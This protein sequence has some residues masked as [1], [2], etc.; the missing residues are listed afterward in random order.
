MEQQWR[1]MT[2]MYEKTMQNVINQVP[3]IVYNAFL[4]MGGI[5]NVAPLQ[6]K[7]PS[8]LQPT[9]MLIEGSPTP[10]GSRNSIRG[11]STRMET[12]SLQDLSSL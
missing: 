1:D 7:G 2:I 10:Q 3:L 8:S 12:V 6:L 5:M 4:G 11:E 9:L